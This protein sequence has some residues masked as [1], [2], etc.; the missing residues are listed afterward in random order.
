MRGLTWILSAFLLL[1]ESSAAQR[2]SA[3]TPLPIDLDNGSGFI[4]CDFPGTKAIQI[5]VSGLPN[6]S[7][8]FSLASVDI[9]L[10][11]SCGGD[12]RNLGMWIKAP[13]SGT[14]MKIYNPGSSSSIYSSFPA[15]LNLSLRDATCLNEPNIDLASWIT[16][17]NKFAT[18]NY[19]AF[20][21]NANINMS[22]F[23]TGINPNGTWT[24]YIAENSSY[25]PCISSASILFTNSTVSSQV[26]AG[27]NCS[28]PIVWSGQPICASTSGKSASPQSPGYFQPNSGPASYESISGMNCQWNAANN[29]DVW[30]KFTATGSGTVCISISGLDGY[31][32]SIVVKDAKV[33][34]NND[35]CSQTAKSKANGDPNWV[36]VS[37][38][39]TSDVIYSGNNVG[40]GTYK[41]QQHCFAAQANETFYLIVDGT[42]GAQSPF[43]IAGTSGPLPAILE[44]NQNTYI[45]QVQNNPTEPVALN[46]TRL[47]TQV[48]SKKLQQ[49]ILIY[50]GFG[51]LQ[52]QNSHWVTGSSEL[53]LNQYMHSGMN[54]IKVL[55][56]DAY[57]SSY[58]Y[59][60]NKQQ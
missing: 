42:S 12:L 52:Y 54:I 9:S 50:D 28:N 20:S 17:T 57:G 35:P 16:N 37:C 34:L 1:P 43:Y 38:P 59:K 26:N 18:G 21:A 47:L 7:S 10:D 60:I 22:D 40:G 48:G 30:V 6:L 13:N 46:G 3:T 58:T 49:R 19:G 8:T 29:N 32:Q 51:R 5:P 2:F 55:L 14:C 36:V 45:K 11:G 33:D 24:I 56:D 41:N 39:S 4:N 23:F 44:Q 15:T 27:D 25:A 53:N 31:L